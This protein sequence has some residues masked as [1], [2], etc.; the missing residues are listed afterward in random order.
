MKPLK[1][2]IDNF[3]QAPELCSAP[4]HPHLEDLGRREFYLTK[5]LWIEA[6]DF[7]QEPVKG[8]F[9]L[10]PPINGQPGNRVRLRYGFV[11][12]CTGFDLGADGQV[13]AVHANYFPDSKSGTEGANTYKVKGNIHWLSVADALPAEIRV[14]DRLFT[15]P[16][17]TGGD[18]D[19]LDFLN[20]KSKSVIQAYVDPSLAN[21]KPEQSFQFERHGYYVADQFDHSTTTPVFN[22]SVGLKDTWKK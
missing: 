17:P 7:M 22:L 11:I 4:I 2:I 14:Y 15:D 10:Y 6:D 12:E 18:K 21:A 16:N 9:R 1:L 13:V 20:P 8:F 3:D 5:E 19:F